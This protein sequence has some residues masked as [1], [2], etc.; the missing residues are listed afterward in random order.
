MG[1][2]NQE[3]ERGAVGLEDPGPRPGIHPLNS[4]FARGRSLDSKKTR[5]RLIKTIAT[6]ATV[7][8]LAVVL[9]ILDVQLSHLSSIHDPAD[10]NIAHAPIAIVL[11]AS[12]TS[13]DTPSDALK[14]RLLTGIALYRTHTVDKLLLSGDDG[15]FH[16]DEIDAMKNFAL[17]NGV[18]NTTDL[19]TDGKGYRTYESCKR[20]H[21]VLGI[22]KAIVVTQ[23]FHIGRAIYLCDNLGIQTEGVTS[24]L[25]TYQKI[26]L[27]W[28]RDLA[29]SAKAWADINL[30]E[31]SPPAK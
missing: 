14:D 7:V 11:G 2:E 27:F 20:A 15:D 18:T 21:D 22:T 10:T 13:D 16:A 8:L 30:I 9:S 5:R 19:L 28:I 6:I 26:V 12:V 29:A 3:V 25:E 4:P 24:D 23:R 1:T 17:A 31:P